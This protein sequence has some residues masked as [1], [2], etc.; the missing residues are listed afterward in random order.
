MRDE[1]EDTSGQE[2]EHR[3]GG[4]MPRG[5]RGV[6]QIVVGSLRGV[7]LQHSGFREGL[8]RVVRFGDGGAERAREF[9]RC[10]RRVRRIPDIAR[11]KPCLA[12][13]GLDRTVPAEAQVEPR[14]RECE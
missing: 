9:I 1:A 10:L 7:L 14:D 4:L 2:G 5:L 12:P 8:H 6:L 3:R 13:R 11:E